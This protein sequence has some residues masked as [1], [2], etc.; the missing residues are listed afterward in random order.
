M[1][2]VPGPSIT[3]FCDRRNTRPAIASNCSASRARRFS[4]RTRGDHP[5]RPQASNILVMM[6]GRRSLV[7]VIDSGVAKALNQPLTGPDAVTG[8]GQMI[9]TPPSTCSPNRRSER[10]R[11][12]YAAATLQPGRRAVRIVVR[13]F[14]VDAGP[15]QRGLQRDPRIIRE[16][17]PPR[18]RRGSAASRNVGPTWRVSAGTQLTALRARAAR[19]A[20]MDPAEAM[21]K[22]RDRRYASAQAALEDI[23]IILRSGR[24]WPAI[25]GLFACASSRAPPRP[26]RGGGCA[27]ARPAAG[28]VTTS[29]MYVRAEHQRGRRCGRRDRTIP[30]RRRSQAGN[31]FPVRRATRRSPTCRGRNGRRAG[32]ARPHRA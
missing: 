25:R 20:G 23:L 3:A 6:H 19:R 1:E 9:G 30:F 21:R 13:R 14:A 26:D 8:S 32:R 17:E 28:V 31:T 10:V 4:T 22:E 27:A 24:C 2:Y 29:V 16:V 12:R 11:R 5:P 18:P 7:K 15:S